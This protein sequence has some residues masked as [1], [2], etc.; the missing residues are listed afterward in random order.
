MR[1]NRFKKKKKKQIRVLPYCLQLL[2]ARFCKRFI[3]LFIEILQV[4]NKNSRKY[5]IGY[6]YSLRCFS[7]CHC[8][9]GPVFGMEQMIPETTRDLA[10]GRNSSKN[11]MKPFLGRQTKC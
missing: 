3:D 5:R 1:L 11:L 6:E 9:S 10:L 4:F 7:G 8:S 2:A